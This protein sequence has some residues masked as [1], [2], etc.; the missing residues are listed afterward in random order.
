MTATDV[1]LGLTLG[2]LLAGAVPAGRAR[3]LLTVPAALSA[4]PLFSAGLP[5][6]AL[7]CA[8]YAVTVLLV[9]G[10]I[11]LTDA[12]PRRPTTRQRTPKRRRR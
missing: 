8:T 3:L 5:V 12:A 7:I 11:A 4:A 2:V 9:R 1:T 10:V 6:G